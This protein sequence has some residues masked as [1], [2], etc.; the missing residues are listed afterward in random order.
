MKIGFGGIDKESKNHFWKK[1]E[2]KGKILGSIYVSKANIAS[3]KSPLDTILKEEE[4]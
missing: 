2:F 4:T 1:M 3:I